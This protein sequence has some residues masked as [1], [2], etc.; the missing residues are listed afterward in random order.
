[1]KSEHEETM[2]ALKALT[3]RKWD[4]IRKSPSYEQVDAVASAF[5]TLAD[6]PTYRVNMAETNIR[7]DRCTPCGT[8]ACHGGWYLY[9]KMLTEP[10][11]WVQNGTIMTIAPHCELPEYI[12]GGI[13]GSEE[14]PDYYDGAHAMAL[15]LGFDCDE[16][17][18]FFFE[19]HPDIWGNENARD[20]FYGHVAFNDVAD[21]ERLCLRDIARHWRGVADRIGKLRQSPQ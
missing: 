15:D 21:P 9:H 19:K 1:M 18:V 7:R 5:E 11:A 6:N 3:R 20:M 13:D 17:M 4:A 2:M 16:H 10:H 8:I 14:H 12:D